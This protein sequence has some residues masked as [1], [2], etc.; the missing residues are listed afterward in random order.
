MIEALVPLIPQFLW[1]TNFVVSKV[2]ISKGLHAMTLTALR[3]AI[4][5]ALLYAYSRL[6][7]LRV[8]LSKE[9]LLPSLTGITGFSALTYLGLTYAKASV[10]GLTMALIPI[11]TS[12]LAA[13]FLKE[14][15]TPLLIASVAA[16]STGVTLLTLDSSGLSW[17]GALLGS[18]AA[19]DWAVYT[20]ASKK[21]MRE[22]SP[23]ESLTSN[24]LMAQPFNF[25]LALPFFSL[26]PMA[27]PE[28]LAGLLY[29]SLV[30][31]FLAY[32]LW[33]YSVN[34][35][36]AAR[37]GV[38]INALPL[39]TLALASASLGEALSGP[40]LAGAALILLALALVTLDY[41]KRLSTS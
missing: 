12:V 31:G 19:L 20:V 36:G 11:F 3:W 10:V 17:L 22:L 23:I 1:A 5:G 39:L 8:V 41:L 38:Y 7:G 15:L 21:A 27:D 14:R 35:V 2:V 13:A 28:V 9:L 37:A 30:P 6:K 32:F 26:A 40:Q 24:A 25:L 29:V 33:L 34:L 18:L 16:G 4:A